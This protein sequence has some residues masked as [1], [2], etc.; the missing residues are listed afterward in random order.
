[1]CRYAMS[2]YK[3]HYACFECR[4]SFKRRLSSDID[5]DNKNQEEPAKCPDC[6]SLMAD[7]GLDFESP[8]K[9]DIKAWKHIKNL[10]TSGITFHSCGCT[11]PGFVPKDYDELV[12]YLE[13]IKKQFI[14]HRRF[15]QHRV[16]PS[17]DREKQKD[18]DNN[19]K[20][21]VNIPQNLKIGTKKKSR[22]D[23]DQAVDY[24]TKNIKC[25]ESKIEELA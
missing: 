15:W 14:D 7:M 10:Y 23:I 20:Y 8:K 16:E 9:K 21:L 5:R 2:S 17:N 19:K 25:I 24:W 6:G 18:W 4:K 13:R 3:P 11:G 1:M 12:S 22:V